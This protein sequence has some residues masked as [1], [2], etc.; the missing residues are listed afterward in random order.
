MRK[1]L[2]TIVVFFFSTVLFGQTLHTLQS[3]AVELDVTM[4]NILFQRYPAE[5]EE[6]K[7]NGID[8]SSPK[9]SPKERY[10]VF[11]DDDLAFVMDSKKE[12]I[13][14]LG[15]DAISYGV[16]SE[17]PELENLIMITRNG[18]SL[19]AFQDAIYPM[20]K[21]FVDEINRCYPDDAKELSEKG[22]D[23]ETL[24]DGYFESFI[25]ITVRIIHDV[26]GNIIH[27]L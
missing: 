3:D 10:Y 22:Y 13:T 17:I 23:N 24:I 27:I 18:V 21:E 11:I 25:T 9:S 5:I 6:L 26:D 7:K 1:L 4:Y 8:L 20:T 2:S 15:N 14:I 16:P 19:T 12:L